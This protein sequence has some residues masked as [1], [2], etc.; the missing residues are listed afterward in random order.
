VDGQQLDRVGL[1]GR[2]D[3]E[4]GAELVL[5]A[6]VGEQ[7]RQRHRPVDRL[8]LRDRLDEQVE[9]VATGLG[10]R[11]HRGGQLDV[12]AGGVDDPPDQV[13]QRLAR[14]RPQVAELAREEGEALERLR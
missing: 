4:A 6:E 1:G 9:V 8:E 5:G 12:D 2:R 3:V 11:A 10:G 7:R 13:E 14:V